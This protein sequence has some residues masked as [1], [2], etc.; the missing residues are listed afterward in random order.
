M[1]LIIG[2]GNPGFKYYNTRHNVGFNAIDM[3]AKSHNIK[4][5]RKEHEA[6]TGQGFIN[7]TKVLLAKPLTYMNNSGRAVR[8]LVDYYDID[9]SDI[10][11]IS[12]DITL[13]AGVL[14]FRSK[15]SSGGHNGL[16]SII[17]SIGSSDFKRLKIGVG[18]VPVGDDVIRHVLSRPDKADRKVVDASVKVAKEAIDYMMCNGFD[19]A[20]S[21][22]NGK[23][24]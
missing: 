4:V 13:D 12:D 5:K 2:L 23:V 14:R 9:I 7:D 15:G 18:Q 24:I 20:M 10:L 6:L 3:I 8:E 1:Y 19:K 16:K 22:Y 17:D 11:I 21:K